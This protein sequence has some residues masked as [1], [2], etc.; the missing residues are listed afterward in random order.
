MSTVL[1]F[2]AV[3]IGNEN[4]MQNPVKKK[5]FKAATVETI[6]KNYNEYCKK[7]GFTHGEFR[8]DSYGYWAWKNEN[9]EVMLLRYVRKEKK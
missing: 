7:K 3:K 6:Y 2:E 9:G 1:V 4:G 5:I 8:S